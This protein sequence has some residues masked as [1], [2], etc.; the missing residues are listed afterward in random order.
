MPLAGAVL[1]VNLPSRIDPARPVSVAR[2]GWRRYRP[3]WLRPRPDPGPDGALLFR[4]YAGIHDEEP[5]QEGGPDADFATVAAG[6]IAI[7]PLQSGAW[8]GDV[9]SWLRQLELDAVVH[10]ALAALDP[11]TVIPHPSAM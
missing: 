7:T 10:A 2:L 5:V 1:N 4:S 11:A 6:R 9:D 3:G 8:P